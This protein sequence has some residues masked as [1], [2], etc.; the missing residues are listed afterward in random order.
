M[1]NFDGNKTVTFTNRKLLN[2]TVSKQ[3]T[4]SMG[5]RT[6]EFTFTVTIPSFANQTISIIKN[7]TP[8]TLTFDDDGKAT[9]TLQ[10][11]QSAVIS[12]I[13]Y[14]TNYT[15]SEAVDSL[16]AQSHQING[17][18]EVTSLTTGTLSLTEDTEVMFTND[19]NIS[20]PTGLFSDATPWVLMSMIAIALALAFLCKRKQPKI[21]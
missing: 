21:E 4:G 8:A 6:K 2:L 18:S 16:Y 5:D 9:F 3:V 1:T 10:S 12:G 11:D 19:C 13:P 15:V 17:G 20:P 7:G 14:G